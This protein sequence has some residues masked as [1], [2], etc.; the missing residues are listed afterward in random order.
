MV[1]RAGDDLDLTPRHREAVGLVVPRELYR[2]RGL[3]GGAG[4]ECLEK[5][6]TVHFA[7]QCL[8]SRNLINSNVDNLF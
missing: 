8:Q 7:R 3:A 1:T 5:H 2:G 6:L 4:P